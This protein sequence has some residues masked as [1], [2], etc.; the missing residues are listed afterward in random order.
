M[1][2]GGPYTL[3]DLKVAKP[4]IWVLG[5]NGRKGF[6]A[7]HRLLENNGGIVGGLLDRIA[8]SRCVEWGASQSW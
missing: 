4:E 7:G 1:E 6:C 3:S 5:S 8:A 2:I